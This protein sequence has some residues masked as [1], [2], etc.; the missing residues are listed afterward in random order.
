MKFFHCLQPP[1]KKRRQGFREEPYYYFEEDEVVWPDINNFYGVR[2]EVYRGLFLSR[3][4]EGKKRNLY[5][6]N[7]LIKDI[8]A[9]NQDHIKVIIEILYS[10]T[11]K[12]YTAQWLRM[13]EM[14]ILVYQEWKQNGCV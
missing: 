14:R 10:H 11:N 5:F 12:K 1:K 3:T 13:G 9:N 4:K 8:V 2:K 6:T 7:S